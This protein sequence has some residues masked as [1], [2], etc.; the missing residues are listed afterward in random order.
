[1]S[2]TTFRD[3]LSRCVVQIKVPGLTASGVL[4]APGMVLTCGHI[5]A[6]SVVNDRGAVQ[7]KHQGR[8]YL[9]R[10]T[11]RT[12]PSDEPIYP[13]PDLAI[14]QVLD[15]PR[16]HPC[17]WICDSPLS[18]RAHL[19]A[20]GHDQTFGQFRFHSV[21]GYFAGVSGAEE[22]A[23]YRFT[24]DEL[25][26]G[27]SGGPVLV[28]ADGAVIALVK[29][30][31]AEGTD[32]GGLLT[33]MRGLW[34]LAGGAELWREHDLFHFAD[35]QWT[36]A[37]EELGQRSEF[38]GILK[39]SDEVELL[40][41]LARLPSE[42]HAESSRVSL[43]SESQRLARQPVSGSSLHPLLKWTWFLAQRLANAEL[44]PELQGWTQVTAGT[45]G[46]GQQFRDWTREL[47]N[48]ATARPPAPVRRAERRA[49]LLGRQSF[50]PANEN[51][52]DQLTAC[53]ADLDAGHFGTT[54]KPDNHL[55]ADPLRHITDFTGSAA[56][57][58]VLLLYL[59]GGLEE[60][61]EGGDLVLDLSARP[62]RDDRPG[63][64]LAQEWMMAEKRPL[65]LRAV[66]EA[67]S[68]VNDQA[69][70]I[71]LL[72]YFRLPDSPA[73]APAAVQRCWPGS[74]GGQASLMV[75]GLERPSSGRFPDMASLASAVIRGQR[76]RAETGENLTVRDLAD[77]VGRLSPHGWSLVPGP[78]FDQGLVLAH[79]PLSKEKIYLN[80][81]LGSSEPTRDIQDRYR[82]TDTSDLPTVTREMQA[83]VDYW[84]SL[85]TTGREHR[86]VA[87]RLLREHKETYRP[88]LEAAKAGRAADVRALIQI[89][90]RPDADTP[91]PPDQGGSLIEQVHKLAT[92]WGII[93]PEDEEF[94]I[95][96]YGPQHVAAALRRGGVRVQKPPE[97]PV[98]PAVPGLPGFEAWL[99]SRNRR[100]LF[101]LIP[102]REQHA[103][104]PAGLVE[105]ASDLESD[106]GLTPQALNDAL[107]DDL[108]A[109]AQTAAQSLRTLNAAGLRSVALYQMATPLRVL[110][111]GRSAD[112]LLRS[113]RDLGLT[114][115]DAR[116][117][118]FAVTHEPKPVDLARRIVGLIDEN[119]VCA[120]LD[121][122]THSESGLVLDGW[123][124]A[125][126]VL[127]GR[128]AEARTKVSR[129]RHESE[130]DADRAWTL[131][132]EAEAI[133]GDLASIAEARRNLP[134]LPPV[135][136]EATFDPDT[137]AVIVSWA[138][139]A[140]IAGEVRYQVQ[141]Y[142]GARRPPSRDA[143]R[144]IGDET[145]ALTIQ[146]R[147]A[148][149]NLPLW[150]TV[151]AVRGGVR[152]PRAETAK[153]EFRRS[154]V[155]DV[156]VQPGDG[157][158]ALRWRTPEGAALVEVHRTDGQSPPRPISAGPSDALDEGLV[159][160]TKYQYQ[161][162]AVYL[163]ENGQRIRSAVRAVPATPERPLPVLPAV[164]IR[165]TPEDDGMLDVADVPEDGGSW[166]LVAS[167]E[168]LRYRA[169]DEIPL[170][171]LSRV[172]EVLRTQART[173][174]PSVVPA[175]AAV[176]VFTVV[177][178]DGERARIGGH[179]AWGPVPAVEGLGAVR[180][181]DQLQVFW[182]QARD[183]EDLSLR[184]DLSYTVTLANPAGQ[185]LQR[186]ICY[187]AL[188][189]TEWPLWL[190]AD[191]GPM[192]LTVTPSR[193]LPGGAAC[194]GRAEVKHVPARLRV[195]YNVRQLPEGRLRRRSGRAEVTLRLESS[196]PIT[197]ERV[198][199][200]VR[201]GDTHPLEYEEENENSL[202]KWVTELRLRPGIP[203]SI[204]L[205]RGHGSYR[206]RCF[207]PES[208]VELL[209]PPVAQRSIRWPE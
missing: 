173:G 4:V 186:R 149:N 97:L 131:L 43:R 75:L 98:I 99:S 31:R 182:R 180:R 144:V 22:E 154:G 140:T 76:D 19:T 106:L 125:R 161:L 54:D 127:E 193:S 71:I 169:G 64:L 7:V 114:D 126:S 128:R 201:R 8:S 23:F 104:V 145:T 10:V 113:A 181:G 67:A 150:Y 45:L 143:G 36:T 20:Y 117:L 74:A 63:T 53:L 112:D 157:K 120:A 42:L 15:I 84:E 39:P 34:T 3:L 137:D 166:L 51:P 151:V 189:E 55:A 119:R 136:I 111:D 94:L 83:T 197:L 110:H 25:A 192:C 12:P 185:V 147:A 195:S 209:H 80:N 208:D 90:S 118:C 196:V 194:A 65:A 82:L 158:V 24:G 14:V 35:R 21:S 49:L 28:G 138:P 172:G 16:P 190:A 59:A 152:S 62:A 88:V 130:H 100:H 141:R 79:E 160:G 78:R 184:K 207:A 30:T 72:D 56:P 29:A 44:A 156:S 135:G 92:L 96:R 108:P 115:R 167:S 87:R 61:G 176:T 58:D 132:D 121:A 198:S 103:G 139:S 191:D 170:A 205:G 109:A 6:E 200:T 129:A 203:V 37:R 142:E 164:S 165:P 123:Q 9:A 81:V 187:S 162:T 47:S 13:Y 168:P 183:R 5:F 57:S 1:M 2:V 68:H 86:T 199:I 107:D 153:A 33:P 124:L 122:L 175:P 134:P 50:W 85:A 41:I 204:A 40:A 77:M 52:V 178:V 38:A 89:L 202:S 116:L 48:A 17:A 148:P 105:N 69:S 66:A 95:Q 27:M 26:H 146:D 93:T 179:I 32:L 171:V 70:L 18:E 46:Q 91:A 177:A 101:D 73:D 60:R 133:A 188:Y 159:N 102:G 155:S 174:L 11:H 206:V 163:T